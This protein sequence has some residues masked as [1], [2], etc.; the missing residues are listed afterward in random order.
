MT[1]IEQA[2]AALGSTA[3]YERAYLEGPDGHLITYS[4]GI[5]GD[6]LAWTVQGTG[7]TMGEALEDA[8]RSKKRRRGR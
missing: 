1:Y 5:R 7:E 8:R 4:V 2:R 6:D 3:V